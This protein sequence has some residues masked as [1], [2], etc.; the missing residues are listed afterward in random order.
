MRADGKD[1]R[2]SRPDDG[3]LRVLPEAATGVPLTFVS[4]A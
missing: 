3:G 2:E 1:T 4:A